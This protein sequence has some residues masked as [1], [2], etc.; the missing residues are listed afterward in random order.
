M[1]SS[2]TSTP[3]PLAQPDPPV[4]RVPQAPELR[5][6]AVRL[7]LLVPLDQM[8]LQVQMALRELVALLAPR[9]RRVLLGRLARLDRLGPRDRRALAAQLDQ[10]DRLAQGLPGLPDLPA[11]RGPLATLGLLE[12]LDLQV[13]LGPGRQGP[14]AAQARRELMEVMALPVPQGQTAREELLDRL[15]HLGLLVPPECLVRLDRRAAGLRAQQGPRVLLALLRGLLDRPEL[16]LLARAL[17]GRPGP[18]ARW[19]RPGRRGP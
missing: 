6:L 11:T 19:A 7:A 13:L 16:V 17:L 4:R 15:A 14:R 8:D 10:L 5:V 12:Q 1:K 2:T 18:Q 9:E 3:T